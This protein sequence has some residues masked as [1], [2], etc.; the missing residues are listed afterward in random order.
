MLAP[1]NCEI[2]NSNSNLTDEIYNSKHL[3]NLSRFDLENYKFQQ[4]NAWGKKHHPPVPTNHSFNNL[5][6]YIVAHI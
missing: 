2:R 1:V 6:I 4:K 3:E 5:E